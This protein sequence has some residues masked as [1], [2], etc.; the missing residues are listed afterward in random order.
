MRS[1]VH[2]AA[3]ALALLSS[4]A[5]P[6]SA[7][8]GAKP[9]SAEPAQPT[10]RWPDGRVNLGS[11]PQ[12]K[13][14]WEVRPGGGGFRAEGPVPFQPWAKALYDYRQARPTLYP[15]LVACKPAGGPSF[16][17]SPG[18]EIVDVPDLKKIFLL[19][20]AGPHSWR[21]IY[22]DGRPHPK[23][24]D[25]RPTYFGHSIGHWQAD[26]LM[27]DSVGFNEKQ[28]LVGAY[29]TTGQLH[30]TERIS[31]PSLKTLVYEATIDDPGAYTKPW[32]GKWTISG[33]TASQWIPGGEMFEY[34]CEDS[35]K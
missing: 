33:A 18:F 15:P 34:I 13:G 19:N 23:P 6:A 4:L 3:L 24:D 1:R 17:N 21:V 5:L 35:T 20:I 8:R 14:Y 26:T 11:T 10:P 9:A 29:P 30:L 7:Q 32:S 16:F 25:L 31:R 27:I 12:E 28:W 2:S 22:M